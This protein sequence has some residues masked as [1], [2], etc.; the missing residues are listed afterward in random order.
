LLLGRVDGDLTGGGA[1]APGSTK[2]LIDDV[3]GKKQQKLLLPLCW[4]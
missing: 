1:S 2:Y 4:S 3:F